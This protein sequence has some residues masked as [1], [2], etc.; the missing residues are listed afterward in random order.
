MQMDCVRAAPNP[1][2]EI[3]MTAF[4][5][6][7]RAGALAPLLSCA[8]LAAW[9]QAPEEGSPDPAPPAAGAALPGTVVERN[10]FLPVDSTGHTGGEYIVVERRVVTKGDSKGATAAEVP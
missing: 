2:Q 1:C 3:S 8:A 6:L 4:I 9:S 10:V 5:R 7:A